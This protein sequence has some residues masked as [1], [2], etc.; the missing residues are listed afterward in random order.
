[1]S[2]RYARGPMSASSPS[3]RPSV[4][5][6]VAVRPRRKGAR[7]RARRQRV[8]R[9]R[10]VVA[11]VEDDQTEARAQVLGVQV[12]RVVRRDRERLHVVL[13]PADDADRAAERRREQVV[14]L[15]HEVE[16]GGDD[17]GAAPLVVDGE[18]R[19]VA[20][21]GPRRQDHH[22]AALLPAPRLEGLRL[23]RARLPVHARARRELGVPAGLV[24]ARRLARHDL[25][26]DVGVR[27]S[28]GAV[29]PRPVVPSPR[30]R[31]RTSLR[32]FAQLQRAGHER[33]GDHRF[34]A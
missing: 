6:G 32:P 17:E 13:A 1:M 28:R 21:P 5:S 2:L 31:E 34:F 7:Q 9:A 25:P 29:A 3:S 20:L 12:E 33:K 4:R 23:V 27:E 24:G 15:P 8:R 30:R 10:Q 22:T 14:P 19:D 16:R 11:L 26:D 18:D